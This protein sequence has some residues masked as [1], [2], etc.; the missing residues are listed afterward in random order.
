MRMYQISR[1][2]ERCV[3][4]AHKSRPH[5]LDKMHEKYKQQ[6]LRAA[7]VVEQSQDA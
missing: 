5:S 1:F 3:A 4:T 7:T 6:L 2:K